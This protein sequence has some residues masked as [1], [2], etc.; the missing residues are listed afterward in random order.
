MLMNEWKQLLNQS[1]PHFQSMMTID[2]AIDQE[3]AKIDNESNNEIEW[4]SPTHKL[5]K[6]L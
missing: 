3:K 2:E 1:H 4:I 5:Q 6:K